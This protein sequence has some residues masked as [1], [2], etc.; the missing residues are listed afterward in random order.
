MKTL[1]FFHFSVRNKQ[2]LAHETSYPMLMLLGMA[3]N[4]SKIKSLLE[5]AKTPNT[6]ATTLNYHLQGRRR[7]WIS[8]TTLNRNDQGIPSERE[9][10]VQLTSFNL[11]V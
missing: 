4:G 5:K 10:L 9:S 1:I 6:L 3:T 11:H 7:A 8:A 2:R